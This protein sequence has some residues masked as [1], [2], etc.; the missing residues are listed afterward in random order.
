MNNG[1][2]DAVRNSRPLVLYPRCSKALTSIPIY[3]IPKL[4]G[5]GQN[6][7]I[8]DYPTSI[9]KHSGPIA[10]GFIFER[11]KEIAD[12]N[13]HP[14]VLVF[15]VAAHAEADFSLALKF[16]HAAN[17]SGAGINYGVLKTFA[18]AHDIGRMATGGNNLRFLET[19]ASPY[20]GVIG[21]EIFLHLADKFLKA[22]NPR[23]AEF[24][25]ILAKVA[26]SHTAGV[27]YSAFSNSNLGIFPHNQTTFQDDLVWGAPLEY[28][29]ERLLIG[30]ADAKTMYPSRKIQYEGKAQVTIGIGAPI[31]ISS[32]L[33]LVDTLIGKA[34]FKLGSTQNE[35]V[36]REIQDWQGE[37]VS[38]ELS[39]HNKT[40]SIIL[41]SGPDKRF[42]ISIDGQTPEELIGFDYIC[43]GNGTIHVQEVVSASRDAVHLRYDHF[44]P[45]NPG[46]IDRAFDEVAGLVG[47][48]N[49]SLVNDGWI[50]PSRIPK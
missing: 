2:I 3:T 30:V 9:F 45:K 47:K 8:P 28:S 21:R 32:G 36:Y 6:A 4:L 10:H 14:Q 11:M 1:S 22:G 48:D 5:A 42:S 19:M 46:Y 50:D 13:R 23:E 15:D 49:Q 43:I 26:S 31:E 38:I 37:P 20:H 18:F 33:L 34:Y 12:V 40:R 7:L 17:L 35:L 25:R 44:D 29:N 27:G 16:A 39:D 41:K 24:C